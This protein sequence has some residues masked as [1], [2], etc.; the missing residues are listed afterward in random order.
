MKLDALSGRAPGRWIAVALVTA[1]LALAMGAVGSEPVGDEAPSHGPGSDCLE[2][3]APVVALAPWVCDERPP[4]LPVTASGVDGQAGVSASNHGPGMGPGC[5]VPT[6]DDRCETWQREG[7]SIVEGGPSGDTVYS[8]GFPPATFNAVDAGTGTAHWTTSEGL[9]E[10]PDLA[11]ISVSPDASTV[12]LTDLQD[13]MDGFANALAY[14][15]ATGELLWETGSF[16]VMTDISANPEVTVAPN[17]ETVFVTSTSPHHPTT[18]WNV[19]VHA[20]DADTGDELWRGVYNHPADRGDFVEGIDVNPDGSQVYVSATSVTG[21]ATFFEYPREISV[22]SFDAATGDI[23]WSS[24][25]S[26]PGGE[27]PVKDDPIVSADGERVYV[28]GTQWNDYP[29]NRNPTADYVTIAYDTTTGDEL[30]DARYDGPPIGVFNSHDRVRA[31]TVDPG[32]DEQVYVT[33]MSGGFGSYSTRTVAYDGAT[34]ERQWLA[35]FDMPGHRFDVPY[36]FEAGPD[37]ERVYVFGESIP[38][39]FAPGS[40][41]TLSYDTDTGEQ[42]WIGRMGDNPTDDVATVETRSVYPNSLA[43]TGSGDYVVPSGLTIRQG[44]YDW[45]FTSFAYEAGAGD[46]LP[47]HAGAS[48]SDS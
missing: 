8:L 3:L 23:A 16:E 19:Q 45:R 32:E 24:T 12:Y 15:A 40:L 42:E 48:V 7:Y 18:A 35:E 10:A 39:P 5:A 14:D 2:T 22:V 30:W 13:E 17:G 20:F 28:A 6:L 26:H 29:H 31:M 44:V 41:V 34:G 37:G 11:D 33:G 46:L 27:T 36:H 21:P 9:S 1:G 25:Y 43:V 47:G 38:Q 4:A